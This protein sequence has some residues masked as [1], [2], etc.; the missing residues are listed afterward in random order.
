MKALASRSKANPSYDDLSA[1]RCSPHD[2]D[3]F[4]KAYQ[5]PRQRKGER[6]L[7]IPLYQLQSDDTG[8]WPP[9]EELHTSSSEGCTNFV[10]VSDIKTSF[11]PIEVKEYNVYGRMERTVSGEGPL[12]LEQLKQGNESVEAQIVTF[13]VKKRF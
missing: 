9:N 4:W 10:R 12:G 6:E 2:W 7:T 11:A 8:S 1:G 5:D 3:L 13:R